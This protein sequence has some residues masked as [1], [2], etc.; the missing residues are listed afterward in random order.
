MKGTRD[1]ALIR[2]MFF[3]FFFFLVRASERGGRGGGEEEGRGSLSCPGPPI[4]PLTLLETSSPPRGGLRQGCGERSAHCCGSGAAGDWCVRGGVGG[5]QVR[6]G[7]ARVPLVPSA[8]PALNPLLPH[9][10]FYRTAKYTPLPILF[11]FS[12]GPPGT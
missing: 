10:F 11:L 5:L 6:D 2:E 4:L 1:K 3:F 12:G 7:S 8:C 9:P